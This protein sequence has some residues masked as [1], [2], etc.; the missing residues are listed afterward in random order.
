MTRVLELIVIGLVLVFITGLING[1]FF[2]VK[3]TKIVLTKSP[4]QLIYSGDNNESIYNIVKEV[5]DIEFHDYRFNDALD[6]RIDTRDTYDTK[7]RVELN[8]T[9]NIKTKRTNK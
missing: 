4:F 5:K 8:E 7:S 2:P 1:N 6:V 9:T 3:K